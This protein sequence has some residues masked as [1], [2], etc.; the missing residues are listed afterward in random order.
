M[1]K[2]QMPDTPWHVGYTKKEN[3]DPRRHKSRCVYLK[4]GICYCKFS[5]SYLTKCGGSSHCKYYSE[6]SE[7]EENQKNE[8][9]LLEHSVRDNFAREENRI[10][11]EKVRYKSKDYYKIH[12]SECESIMVPYEEQMTK[13]KVKEYI[14]TYYNNY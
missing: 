9:M 1:E 13:E 3:N 8:Q 12:L 6:T 2:K 4:K 7:K 14:K 11:I 5:G 10:Q